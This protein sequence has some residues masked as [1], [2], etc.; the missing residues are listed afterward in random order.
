MVGFDE[1]SVELLGLREDVPALLAA[2][3]VFVLSSAH[4]GLPNV[5]MEAL[6]AGLPVVATDVGGV[7]ELVEEGISGFVVPPSDSEALAKG[8]AD[9][10]ALDTRR[11][12]EM[13]E[14][15]RRHIQA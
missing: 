6:A 10:M 1:D 13:G 3:D 5:V 15:G 4:E 8:M 9:M 2:A 7:R 12:D 14:A 11:R